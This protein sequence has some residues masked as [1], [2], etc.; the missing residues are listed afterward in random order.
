M[1]GRRDAPYHLE[2][3]TRRGH[4]VPGAPS[5]DNLLVFY[6]PTYGTY[7]AAL[8]R[9]KAQGFSPVPSLNPYWDESG[10]TFE[11]GEGYRVVFYNGAWPPS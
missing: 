7:A 1:L 8:Q 11:D 6:L 2:F 5:Q 10:T 9:M 4:V 3:T